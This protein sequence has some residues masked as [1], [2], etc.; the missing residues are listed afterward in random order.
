MLYLF[1]HDRI[2][3]TM[4]L[5]I[6]LYSIVY[7]ETLVA[8]IFWMEMQDKIQHALLVATKKFHNC[9]I[10]GSLNNMIGNVFPLILCTRAKSL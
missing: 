6:I 1:D 8:R 4:E 10:E 7:V 3:V 5:N 2:C 9:L